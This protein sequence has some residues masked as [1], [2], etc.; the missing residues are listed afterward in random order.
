MQ[1]TFEAWGK[2]GYRAHILVPEGYPKPIHGLVLGDVVLFR[3]TGRNYTDIM[4]KYTTVPLK[5]Q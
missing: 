4:N 2:P 1:R 3:I 5:V